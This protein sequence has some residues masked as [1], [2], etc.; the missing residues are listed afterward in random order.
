MSEQKLMPQGRTLL[1]GKVIY[2]FGQSTID[3]VVRRLSDHGATISV[4]SPLG[5]P[6]QFQLFIA[7]EGMP[8]PCK[9]VWQS[10]KELGLE[11]ELSDSRHQDR[12][13]APPAPPERRDEQMVRGQMLALEVGA[14]RNPDRDSAA[15][16]RFARPIHQSRVSPDVEIAGSGRRQQASLRR[17]DVSR[18]RYQRLS[19]HARRSGCL[20][21]QS[22]KPGP[23]RRHHRA[24]SAPV[25]RRGHPHAMRGSSERRP[26]A[27]LH[28]M[29]PISSGMPT[30]WKC[31]A[32][33]WTTC[34]RAC[35]CSM[36]ISTHI[37]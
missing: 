32:M 25:E 1:A 17:A 30:N 28:C 22:R 2:N 4:E 34:R 5:I 3:C 9:V 24:R 20:H 26:D 11:F 16:Q 7:D 8:R 12:S 6:R 31:C 14:R 27:Q 23:G 13:A 10:D 36:R 33:R 21:R 35:C 19:D 29:S 37:S 15:R 18:P